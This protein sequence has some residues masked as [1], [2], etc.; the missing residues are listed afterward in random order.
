MKTV[1]AAVLSCLLLF[2]FGNLALADDNCR[3]WAPLYEQAANNGLVQVEMD[4][5]QLRLFLVAFNNIPPR[6]ELK[7]DHIFVVANKEDVSV[8]FVNKGCLEFVSQIDI[9]IFIKL[10]QGGV[11][12]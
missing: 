8:A 7:A 4:D 11:S 9:D 3:A 1:F 12:I 5:N 6:S 10:L 2:P